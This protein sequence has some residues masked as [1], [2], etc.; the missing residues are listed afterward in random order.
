[1]NW[2]KF[3][4][5]ASW[6]INTC[7]GEKLRAQYNAMTDANCMNCD[8]FFHCQG[9]YDAVYLCGKTA[10]NIRIA[11]KISDCRE[12]A[13]GGDSADSQA[14]QRAN[15]FGR[16]GVTHKTTIEEINDAIERTFSVP[17]RHIDL[18]LDLSK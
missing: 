6:D 4:W 16:D 14:D 18:C 2:T 17:C 13:Q 5:C 11:K 10:N 9:N 1:M 12:A 7:P 15:K 8:K 3:L